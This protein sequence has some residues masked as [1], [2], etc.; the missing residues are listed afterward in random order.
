MT[1]TDANGLSTSKIVNI[2]PRKSELEPGDLAAGLGLVRRRRSRQHAAHRHRASRASSASSPRPNSA[3]AQD[4]TPLQ[5]AG[6][7]DGK[8]IRHVITTP[9]D[10]TTYTASYVPSQP[11]TAKYYDNTTFS[12][13]PVLTRQDPNDQLRLGRGLT[14]P[15]R[16]RRR[17]LGSLDQDPV[18]R[19]RP[20][21]VHRRR[22]RRRPALHRRKAGDRP[23]AGPGQHGVQPRRRA[24]RGP[25]HDQDGVRRARRRRDGLARTGTARPTSRRTLT[26][27]Q[28]WN[29]PPG[30]NAIPGTSPELAR[31]EEA[32][33]H[34]WGEGSPG[35][36]IAPNRFVARWTRTMSFAPGDYEFAVTADDGVRL[37]VDGVRVI[38]QWIDQGPTTYRTT[39]P[40]DGGPHDDRHGVLR[41]RRRRGGPAELHRGRRST[42][43]GRVSRRVL[44]HAR[45]HR[46]PRRSRPGRPT[47]CATTRRSTSTGARA[48]RAPASRRTTSSRAG[49]RPSC[50][51]PALYRFTGGRDDGMRAYLDNVPVV[52]EWTFGNADYSV[53]KVVTGG[54]HELRVEY[55][56]GG[57]GARAEFDYERIGDVVATDGGYAAEY[58][59][60]RNLH[61]H[62]R[63]DPHGRR[64]RLRLGR[65]RARRRRARG[66]L[67][68]PVDQVR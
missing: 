32:I 64:R 12:G 43:R 52:D 13:A 29:A 5:F 25:A 56:E 9:E 38:D 41:E 61:G 7:S 40:L 11:F 20:L 33:D 24:R 14:R 36:G 44:E 58:F 1:A 51:R 35:P 57:G 53:D 4:G 66:Q 65:R 23:V 47:S 68:G 67:L 16:P 62:A 3:V 31:D 37:Y 54:P 26:S 15:S 17:L 45:R 63:A 6:W 21:P 28:Y 18:L 59:A 34:D 10:D 22:R 39:L 50:C 30:V 55:F 49:R 42:H 27:A 19:R 46:H 60:N 48:R 8:S 2:L